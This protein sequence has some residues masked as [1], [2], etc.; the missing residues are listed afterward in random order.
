VCSCVSSNRAAIRLDVPFVAQPPDRCGT[1][2]VEMI[3]RY[4]GVT[5][6][7]AALDR[8]IHIPALAGSIPALLV[9]GSRR[10]GFAAD[11]LVVAEEEIYRKL[12]AGSPLVVLLAPAGDDPR[13]HFIVATGANPRTG[14]LRVHSGNRANRWWPATSWRSRWEQAGRQ[15]VWIRPE[16]AAA[17]GLDGAPGLGEDD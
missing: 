14:A 7:P 8:A 15:I 17:A 4:Y 3:L 1:A 2:A 11:S 16:P 5:P 10:A 13:G 12:A 9:E 6:D